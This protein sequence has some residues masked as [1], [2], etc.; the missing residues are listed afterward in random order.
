[1][2]LERNFKRTA[3]AELKKQGWIFLQLEPGAGIPMGFPDTLALSPTGYKC[4]IEWKTSPTAK[5][6]PLQEYWNEKLNE[7]GH[8]AF[9]VNP[10]NW[11]EVRGI[12]VSESGRLS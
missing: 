3:Q 11:E 10:E 1:M 7:M 6:Q 5:K 8:E 2:A 4:F 9:F 12:I